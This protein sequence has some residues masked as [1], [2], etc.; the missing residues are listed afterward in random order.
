MSNEANSPTGAAEAAPA[1]LPAFDPGVDHFARLGL[2]PAI[3]LDREA[4]E[5]AYLER[6]RT[7]HPDRFATAA[8]SLRRLAME[9]ASAVN[10]AYRTLRDGVRRAE[11]VVKLGGIDLDS[12][13]PER[14][15]PHPDQSFLMEMI[16]RREALDDARDEGEDALEDLRDAVEDERDAEVEAAMAALER[17]DVKSAAR[18]LVT[19]RYLARYLE[20]IA[21]SLGEDEGEGA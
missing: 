10:E 5:A 15:A 14:G 2:R 21:I 4:L 18:R 13:D 16:E 17:D 7:T 11:Y 8:P 20:E 1:N 9:H 6:S 19:A 12:S 3:R